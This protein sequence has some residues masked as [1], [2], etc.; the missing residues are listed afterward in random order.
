MTVLI[1]IELLMMKGECGNRRSNDA[2]MKETNEENTSANKNK[3]KLVE[4]KL[5]LYKHF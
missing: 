1:T 4:K 3:I 2:K 5:L